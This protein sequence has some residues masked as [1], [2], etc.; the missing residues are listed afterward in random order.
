VSSQ[1]ITLSEPLIRLLDTQ[2]KT[3]RFKDASAAVQEAVWSFFVGPVSPFEEYRVTAEEVEKSAR[4]DLA[5]IKS[6]RK[7]GRLKPWK[8]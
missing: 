7:A 3:G 8:P 1:H 6:D 2:V 4:R 5:A